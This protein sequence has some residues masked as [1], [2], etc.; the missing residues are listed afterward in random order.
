MDKD[1]EDFQKPSILGVQPQRKT[2]REGLVKAAL[3]GI[4]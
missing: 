3:K 2:H 4:L 1:I